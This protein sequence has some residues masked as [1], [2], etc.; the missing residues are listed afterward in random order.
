MRAST[1]ACARSPPPAP[2][3]QHEKEAKEALVKSIAGICAR[4]DALKKKLYARFGRS[5]NLEDAPAA[6]R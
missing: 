2:V 6:A 3:L 5:I 1:L 4:Q